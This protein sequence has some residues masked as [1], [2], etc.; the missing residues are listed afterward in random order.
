MIFLLV[1]YEK[2][3]FLFLIGL[4]LIYTELRIERYDVEGVCLCLLVVVI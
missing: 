3:A 1:I 4:V 2:T